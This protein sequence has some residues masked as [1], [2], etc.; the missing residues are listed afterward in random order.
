MFENLFEK[1]AKINEFDYEAPYIEVEKLALDGFN[2]VFHMLQSLGWDKNRTEEEI[3]RVHNK[4]IYLVT[5]NGKTA[6]LHDLPGKVTIEIMGYDDEEQTLT[7]DP[8]EARFDPNDR[9]ETLYISEETFD[10]Q[11]D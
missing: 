4:G 9:T 3:V 1:L 10:E 7:G 5:N 2:D 6:E 11:V 8:V